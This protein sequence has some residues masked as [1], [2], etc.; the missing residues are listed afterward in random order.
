[1]IR[2][3]ER[4]QRRH[5]TDQK[6]AQN[7]LETN[8]QNVLLKDHVINHPPEG[9]ET[10]QGRSHLTDV[11]DVRVLVRDHVAEVQGGTRTDLAVEVQEKPGTGHEAVVQEGTGIGHVVGVLEEGRGTDP[12]VGALG[13]TGIGHVVLFQRPLT[14]RKSECFIGAWTCCYAFLMAFKFGIYSH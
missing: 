6:N 1:V 13:E 3:K 11:M 10:G 4:T 14:S 12:A 9:K 8:L 2:V 5:V 7:D